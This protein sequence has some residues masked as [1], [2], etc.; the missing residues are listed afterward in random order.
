MDDSNLVRPRVTV[1]SPE[2]IEQTHAYAL[3]ILSA[4][5]VR[6]DSLAAREVF[7]ASSGAKLVDGDRVFFEHELVEWAINAAPEIVQVYNRSGDAVLRL[8]EDRTRFGIGVTNLYYQDP[9]TDEVTPFTRKHMESSVRLGQVLPQFD[10]VST[11]GIIQDIS[12]K[13]ADLYAALEMIANTTKPLVILISDENLFDPALDLLERLHGDLAEKPFVIPYF[14]PVTPLILNEGTTDKMLAAIHRGLPLICSNY[15][16]AGMSTPITPA[17]TLALLTAELL[18]GLVF[19][20]LVKEGTPV[21]LGSLPAY[22]DMKSMVDYYDPLTMLLNL[23]CA[24]MMAHYRL[25]HAGTSGSGLGWGPDLPASGSL[26]LNHLTSCMGKVGLAPF[27]G[28]N[29]GSK[30]FSPAMVVYADEVIEQ[31]RRFTGGFRL[32]D[33]NLGLAEIVEAGPGG[34]FL[35]S[36]LTLA[37][38]KR[39]YAPSRFFPRLSLE[40]WQDQGRPQADR[41]LREYTRQLLAEGAPPGDHDELIARGEAFIQKFSA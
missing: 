2:Q 14:N 40:T 19:C 21:I 30:V 23:A 37:R 24:E 22:F 20:Q 3:K 16:M 33:E 29:L 35:T 10:V 28:G 9:L 41:L 4:V 39:D 1:L 26:W 36:E 25:P 5:G 17:G 8:G 6:V 7:A 11:T 12:P 31:A 32:D 15:G 27:V 13:I 18:G 38:F 34:H